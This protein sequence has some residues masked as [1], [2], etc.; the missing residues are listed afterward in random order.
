MNSGTDKSKN[1]DGNYTCHIETSISNLSG[2]M[3]IEKY[4]RRQ[5]IILK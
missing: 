5:E 2:I 3:V 1:T 4:A